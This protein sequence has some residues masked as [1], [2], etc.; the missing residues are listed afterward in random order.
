MVSDV[1]RQRG[2]PVRIVEGARFVSGAAEPRAYAAT[3]D[4]GTRIRDRA[5]TTAVASRAARISGAVVPETADVHNDLGIAC[6]SKRP[7]RSGDRRIPSG[8]VDID[9]D[10]AETHWHLGAALA[11]SGAISTEAATQLCADPCSAIRQTRMR[12][13]DLDTVM[14][15]APP[16]PTFSLT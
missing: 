2:V 5:P 16:K 4:E 1:L 6:A 7:D 3:P 14:R 15:H 13:H 8:A 12:R 9:P 10:S 11:S